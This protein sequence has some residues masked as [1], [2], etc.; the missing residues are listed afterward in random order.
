MANE[1]K[2]FAKCVFENITHY[3]AKQG[4][5]YEKVKVRKTNKQKTE[6]LRL[7]RRKIRKR[8]GIYTHYTAKKNRDFCQH[9]IG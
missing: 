9:I 6:G 3:R 7:M 4:N 2:R 5:E 1:D 8:E